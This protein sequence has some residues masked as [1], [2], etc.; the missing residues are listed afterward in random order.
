MLTVAMVFSKYPLPAYATAGTADETEVLTEADEENGTVSEDSGLTDP[1]AGELYI[2]GIDNGEL[3]GNPQDGYKL[4]SDGTVTLNGFTISDNNA[5]AEGKI[6]I[7]KNSDQEKNIPIAS[8]SSGTT[9]AY[10]EF[11]EDTEHCS[12]I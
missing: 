11:G 9:D 1:A 12:S 3:E 10:L 5:G 2:S 7:Y 6:K 8:A 4:K